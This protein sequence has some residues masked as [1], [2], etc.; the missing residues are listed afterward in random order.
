LIDLSSEVM[1]SE[2]MRAGEER[3]GETTETIIGRAVRPYCGDHR[4]V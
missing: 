4:P 3:D 1:R 2:E